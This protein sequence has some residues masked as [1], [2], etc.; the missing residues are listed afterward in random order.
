VTDG[1]FTEVSCLGIPSI[2]DFLK[3]ENNPYKNPFGTEVALFRTSEGGMSRMAVSWDSPGDSGERG[4]IRGQK[5]SFYGKYQGLVKELPALV[6]H[7]VHNRDHY[8]SKE[9]C[10]AQSENYV[11]DSGPKNITFSPPK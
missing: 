7:K 3:P 4:R 11:H 1:S 2:T 6:D 5:G 10:K 9:C 8:Q